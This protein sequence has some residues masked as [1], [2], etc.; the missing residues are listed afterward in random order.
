MEI[1]Q[2]PYPDALP[3]RAESFRPALLFEL[4]HQTCRS[5]HVRVQRTL[6]WG[7]DPGAL[8]SR[9]LLRSCDLLVYV[10]QFPVCSFPHLC[11][12]L[13]G[14]LEL[15]LA[16]FIVGKRVRIKLGQGALPAVAF[17]SPHKSK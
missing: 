11:L 10:S 13:G 1:I 6:A 5:K 7:W 9:F 15:K 4:S 14:E 3:N 2:S 16:M 12:L 8:H 17:F